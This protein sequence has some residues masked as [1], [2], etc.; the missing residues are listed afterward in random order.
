MAFGSRTH[1]HKLVR[2][3]AL[4]Q[5]LNE[6]P[7]GK[8]AQSC[9]RKRACTQEPWTSKQHNKV[10]LKAAVRWTFSGY[11]RSTSTNTL[12]RKEIRSKF[13]PPVRMGLG[14]EPPISI[15]LNTR[16]AGELQ[17]CE[18]LKKETGTN[19]TGSW[20]GL[21]SRSVFI[22]RDGSQGVFCVQ[23]RKGLL[24]HIKHTVEVETKLL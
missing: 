12:A 19:L 20:Q 7:T 11:K 8:P 10:N 9:P 22:W 2:A 5:D 17:C 23:A 24:L 18:H 6:N 16:H 14:G 15:A 13:T 3:N 4:A 21:N 1:A